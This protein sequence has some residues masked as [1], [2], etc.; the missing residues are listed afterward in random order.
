MKKIII[1]S[2]FVLVILIY[3]FKSMHFQNANPALQHCDMNATKAQL[4]PLIKPYV[5]DGFK[6]TKIMFKNKPQ[7]KEVEIPLFY[8][9][10]YRIVFLTN[11]LPLDVDINIYN[12]AN[13]ARKRTLFYS[14][15]DAPK[16]DTLTFETDRAKE[17]FIEYDIP[18]TDTM[19]SGC[20]SFMIGYMEEEE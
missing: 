3:G 13:T 19:K 10:S 1:P 16:S 9:E 17:F 8:G 12:K 18:A 14:S 6:L 15:K 5:I 11:E 7:K 2:L 20:V 4:T